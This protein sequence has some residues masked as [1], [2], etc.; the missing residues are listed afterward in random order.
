MLQVKKEKEREGK[1]HVGFIYYAFFNF[2]LLFYPPKIVICAT[3]KKTN[4]ALSFL[5]FH[6]LWAM[7]SLDV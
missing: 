5:T 2:L 6:C 1:R 3:A 4:H 7:C